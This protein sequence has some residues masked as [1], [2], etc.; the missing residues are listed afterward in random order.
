MR[1]EELDKS[2]DLADVEQT[3]TTNLLGPIRM[4]DALIEPPIAQRNAAIVNVT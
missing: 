4:I 3:I 1:F 2:R